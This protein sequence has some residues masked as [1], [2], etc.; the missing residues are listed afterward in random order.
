MMT[1]E[2]S[3]SKFDEELTFD[4]SGADEELTMIS[5]RTRVRDMIQ[6]FERTNIN[7]PEEM[8][9]P[10]ERR[11][12]YSSGNL[13]PPHIMY[14]QDRNS[15]VSVNSILSAAS[16]A[17]L[18]SNSSGFISDRK[19]GTDYQLPPT[20]HRPAPPPPEPFND[21]SSTASPSPIP[22][23]YAHL[24]EKR[25]SLSSPNRSPQVQRRVRQPPCIR[26]KS[27]VLNHNHQG[28]TLWSYG[29]KQKDL[30][31]LLRLKRSDSEE[32]N[33]TNRNS[34][35]DSSDNATTSENDD[36]VS[37][38]VRTETVSMD[39]LKN[40]EGGSDIDDLSGSDGSGERSNYDNVSIKSISSF[41][42]MTP[43]HQYD[44]VTVS[45]DEFGS[46]LCPGLDREFLTV[47]AVNEWCIT[48]SAEKVIIPAES[49]K[50][51]YK[52]RLRERVNELIHT[53]TVYVERLRHVVEDYLPEMNRTDLPTQMRGLKPEIFANIDR[54]YKFHNEEFLPAL[55][56]C[57]NDLRKLGQCF[58]RFEQKFN[59]YVMYSRNNK[60]ATKLVFEHKKFFQEIQHVLGARL[61]LSSYLLEP[62][63]R[64]PRYKLFLDDLVKTYVNYETEKAETESRI[65]D[66]SDDS[67][68]TG[69]S[70]GELSENEESP[71]DSLKH[72]KVMV[73]YVLTAVDGIMA[74]E[75]IRESPINLLHQGRLLLQSEFTALDHTRRRRT[76]MRVFLFD[77]VILLTAVYRKQL[78]VELFLYRDHIPIDDLG[79]T[80]KE[81]DKY[82]FTVW[83][84]NRNLKSYKLETREPA[85]RDAWVEEITSLLWEQATQKKELLLRNRSNRVSVASMNSEDSVSSEQ[86]PDKYNSLRGVPGE[87]R[88]PGDKKFRRTTWYCE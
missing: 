17:S 48:K 67:D 46:E 33:D 64:I 10:V 69:G 6:R 79:I 87:V 70:N 14:S 12:K 9:E 28:D 75:N 85:I 43:Y 34:Q 77:K 56:D 86:N 50:D 36:N 30:E 1:K 39:T 71:L 7:I 38:D 82:K 80:A 66:L 60:R 74:L 45:S 29:V 84:K 32:E 31:M 22:S 42:N 35:D 11:K 78:T 20:P 61:D 24:S 16:E 57:E 83:Y 52:R 68:E 4:A 65:S 72:A 81:H 25:P 21:S 13:Y 49:K 3:Y 8:E 76:L 40:E 88:R 41:D 15:T 37:D 51:K 47:S 55:K 18:S 2:T 44:S 54:I 26:R 73:E 62:V 59:M 23:D 5:D 53:E 63:Q 19:S 27:L 58:R